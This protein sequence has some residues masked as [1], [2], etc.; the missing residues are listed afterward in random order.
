LTVKG[1]FHGTY[2]W[3]HGSTYDA[4]SDLLLGLER[5]I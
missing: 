1:L 4:H 5:R 3:S 2:R